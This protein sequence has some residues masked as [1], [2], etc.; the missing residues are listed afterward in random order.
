LQLFVGVLLFK[1]KMSNLKKK[2]LPSPGE[3][4]LKYLNKIA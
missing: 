2:I 4:K 1:N 3:G